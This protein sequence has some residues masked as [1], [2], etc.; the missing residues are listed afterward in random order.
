MR[1]F[2]LRSAQARTLEQ[3]VREPSLAGSIQNNN[4]GWQ[5]EKAALEDTITA[6]QLSV[7]DKKDELVKKTLRLSNLD[8]QMA[9]IQQNTKNLISAAE[10]K[11]QKEAGD[12]TREH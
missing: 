9:D 8:N 12:A 7:N 2:S 10:N 5:V 11:A 6:L 3:I 1:T 4:A